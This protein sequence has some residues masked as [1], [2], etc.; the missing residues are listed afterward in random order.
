M[1]LKKLTPQKQEFWDYA[2]NDF[3]FNDE[4]QTVN[5]F[6][7][8]AKAYL[9]PK[10]EELALEELCFNFTKLPLQNGSQV[11]GRYKR[12]DGL[13]VVEIDNEHKFDMFEMIGVF[14]HEYRHFI[15]DMVYSHLNDNL[16]KID[17]SENIDPRWR[18]L[19]GYDYTKHVFHD[20]AKRGNINEQFVNV[21]LHICPNTQDTQRLEYISAAYEVD[22]RAFSYSILQE[23]REDCHL[24]G[25][26]NCIKLIDNEIKKVDALHKE[27]YEQMGKIG[28]SFTS[29]Q[30]FAQEATTFQHEIDKAAASDNIDMAKLEK[31]QK[32]IYDILRQGLGFWQD[33]YLQHNESKQFEAYLT[34]ALKSCHENNCE[35]GTAMIEEE[36]YSGKYS[37]AETINLDEII[38]KITSDEWE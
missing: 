37:V 8:F 36:F 17:F 34:E 4:E 27:Y 31:C 38:K 2:L 7:T 14:A 18:A 33:Y 25:S 32:L 3:T 21:G 26:E 13:P 28:E 15:Q 35:M 11:A 10:F 22:A 1:A 16:G 20:W 23:L 29:G 12:I 30:Y 24:L 5:F 6:Y 9:E 19:V